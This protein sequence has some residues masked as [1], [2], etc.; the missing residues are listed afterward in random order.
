MYQK[1]KGHKIHFFKMY[2]EIGGVESSSQYCFFT[3]HRGSLDNCNIFLPLLKK[4][5]KFLSTPLQLSFL[6][7]NK[8]I[9]VFL[10][11]LF[12][13]DTLDFYLPYQI[14]ISLRFTFLL[15]F[16]YILFHKLYVWL[17]V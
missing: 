4:I 3:C 1:Y 2:R 17:C 7:L 8:H 12:F 15:F 11:A 13:N 5:K 6:F 16:L 14:S 9:C 10:K